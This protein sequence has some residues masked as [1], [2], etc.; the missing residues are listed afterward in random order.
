MSPGNKGGSCHVT[1]AKPGR[2][3]SMS[4][5]QELSRIRISYGASQEAGEGDRTMADLAE[6]TRVPFKS[7][8]VGD[9]M[10]DSHFSSTFPAGC[11]G[12]IKGLGHGDPSQ[13]A[14]GAKACCHPLVASILGMI[15]TRLQGVDTLE[16]QL[17][18]MAIVNFLT[19]ELIVLGPALTLHQT[20]RLKGFHQLNCGNCR[21]CVA[22]RCDG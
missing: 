7:C 19:D 20:Q 3:D 16:M 1:K 17:G 5:A 6:C 9:T 15:Q 14:V 10:P 4:K 21:F 11:E 22:N 12:G 13:R 18:P 8:I 2:G